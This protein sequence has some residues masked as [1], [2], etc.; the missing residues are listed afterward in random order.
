MRKANIQQSPEEDFPLDN[1]GRKRDVSAG[2][3]LTHHGPWFNRRGK[4]PAGIRFGRWRGGL[5]D[6]TPSLACHAPDD[7][8]ALLRRGHPTLS[9][10]GFGGINGGLLFA[11]G[12][13]L[14]EPRLITGFDDR[15]ASQ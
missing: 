6:E 4:R 7:D 11:R 2:P 15:A 5:R 9:S 13:A 12:R 8:V 1:M 14:L 10:L 3:D